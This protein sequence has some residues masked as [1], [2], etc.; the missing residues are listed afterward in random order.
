LAE[1]HGADLLRERVTIDG[2]L[3]PEQVSGFAA[4]A[5][6]RLDH[7]PSPPFGR[8]VGG[9]GDVHDPSAIVRQHHEAEQQLESERRDDEV[10]APTSALPFGEHPS[11]PDPEDAV[12]VLDPQSRDAAL[13]DGELVTEGAFS[14]ARRVR[15]RA[16]VGMAADR[17]SGGLVSAS[18]PRYRGHSP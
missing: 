17:R 13:E 8:G 12:G 16:S 11:H 15:S 18:E 1:A 9:D 7:L 14:R 4:I 10:E 2:V 5:R 3:I 6:E